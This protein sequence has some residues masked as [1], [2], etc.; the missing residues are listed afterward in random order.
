MKNDNS[1]LTTNELERAT[2]ELSLL[3]CLNSASNQ[4]DPLEEVLQKTARG[5]REIFSLAACN[6]FLLEE[7]KEHLKLVEYSIESAVIEKIEELSGF[8]ARGFVVPLFEGSSFTRAIKN[9]E[10]VYSENLEQ[11]FGDYFKEKSMRRLA[12]MAASVSGYRSSIRVPLILE[13]EAMGL[14]GVASKEII[15]DE[16]AEALKSL[17]SQIALT[18]GKVMA[19]KELK[20]SE[21]RLRLLSDAAQAGICVHDEGILLDANNKYVEMFGY[22]SLKDMIGINVFKLVTEKSLDTTRDHIKSESE[23]PYEAELLRKDGSTFPGILQGRQYP[24]KGKMKRVVSITDISVHKEAENRIKAS[25]EE[26]EVLLKE[27]HHRVKNNMAIIASML[28]MQM[29]QTENQ[30][31]VNLLMSS[32]NRIRAMS[33]VHELLYASDTLSEIKLKQYVETLAINI[34]SS[35]R[36]E[37]G[38]IDLKIDVQQVPLDLNK[39]IPVGLI[40]NEA[41]TNSVKH[42]FH[43]VKD[44]VMSIKVL[45][46]GNDFVLVIEDNGLGIKGK[47]FK[48]CKSLGGKIMNAL[49]EQLMGKFNISSDESGTTVEVK[50][51][52]HDA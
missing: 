34:V 40:L 52:I 45:K 46:D 44:P 41:I 28:S 49:A 29:S 15:S 16:D 25:L 30:D 33:L 8:R 6:I 7:D 14:L 19:A 35:L 13:G 37:A 17:A 38:N 47:D 1:G 27:V 23:E 3:H 20:E 18:L 9:Q 51:P 4:G 2:R 48:E 5:I 21:E 22:D 10:T 43:N 11:V 31:S 50:C 42:A 36:E 12:L 26:K 39:L 24:I 32:F